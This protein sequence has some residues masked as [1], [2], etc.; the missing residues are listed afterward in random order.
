[1]DGSAALDL[2]SPDPEFCQ[3]P[4]PLFADLRA[5]TPVRRVCYCGLAAWLLTRS[6]D[7]ARVLTDPRFSNDIHQSGPDNR[8]V[9]WLFGMDHMGLSHHMGFNDPPEHTRL[10]RLVSKVFTPRRIEAARPMI[11]RI[12]DDLIGAFGP[13]GHAELLSEFAW[14]LPSTVITELLGVPGRD[15][16]RFLGWVH[17]ILGPGAED[18]EDI[19]ATFTYVVAYL[20]QL[21]DS[22]RGQSAGDANDILS[23]LVA[24]QQR[25]DELTDTELRS[26]SFA[27]L[28]GGFETTSLLIGNGMLALLRNPEQM[29]LLR[30]N[31]DLISQAIEEFLRYDTPVD[32]ST[33]RFAR[34]DVYIGDTLVQAGEAVLC[35]FAS[36]NRDLPVTG[37]ADH[38]DI[39]RPDVRHM[40]FGHGPHFCLGAPLARLEGQIAFRALLERCPDMVLTAQPDE[41]VK[42]PGVFTRRLAVLPVSFTPR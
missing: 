22:K 30:A 32:C 26:L 6:E 40:S 15:R 2:S 21:I 36:A 20:T 39:S 24:A 18:P 5:Q 25:G 7:I 1:M 3:D 28:A 38:L 17:A 10:R 14:P 16:E 31:P 13:R 11:Q 34:E 29:A 37:D 9:P 4:Y 12:T 33:P 35:M 42:K 41:L 19:A 27:L 23:D 8:D